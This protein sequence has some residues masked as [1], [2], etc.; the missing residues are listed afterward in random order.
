MSEVN[1][2]SND[3][4]NIDD[5]VTPSN[6]YQCIQEI[7]EIVN[8]YVL[9]LDS[10][11]ILQNQ[12]VEDYL[13]DIDDLLIDLGSYFAAETQENFILGLNLSKILFKFNMIKNYIT[14]VSKETE[15]IKKTQILED[16][17]FQ[18]NEIET[19]LNYRKSVHDLSI[20]N[21]DSMLKF[22]EL[23]DKI[24]K[25]EL[26]VA[27]LRNLKVQEIYSNE[28]AD[29]YKFA[30]NY[31]IAFYILILFSGFYFLGLTFYISEFNLYFVTIE[32]PEKIHGILNHEFYIQKIS[33]LIL[34]TTLA[35][36]LLKRS[37]MN[38]RLADDAYRTAKELDALP[39]YMEGMPEELKEKIRFDL[40]YKYFGNGIHH[41]SYTSGENLMHE[42]IKAN[43]DF[44]KAVKDLSPKNDEKN[45]KFTTI[46][47]K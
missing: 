17:L 16:I 30:R 44:I 39:R 42:N 45:E 24:N 35:A 43:T 5:L 2:G 47:S 26:L 36:F 19:F 10:G 8:N 6:I 20:I 21:K 14:S 4:D 41:Y 31:E 32:F 25:S 34:T 11:I 18:L 12:G 15:V 22:G 23:E 29:F 27:D 3:E 33:F 7:S 37:F 1:I 9:E 46:E 40:A 28:S 38:R 13:I